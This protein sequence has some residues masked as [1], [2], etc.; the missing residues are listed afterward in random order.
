MCYGTKRS[1]RRIW[2]LIFVLTSINELVRREK[3]IYNAI[4][5][6][7]NKANT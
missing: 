3:Y 1:F 6:I 4:T 2:G 7:K 5:R